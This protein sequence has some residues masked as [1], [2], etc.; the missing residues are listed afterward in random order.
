MQLGTIVSVIKN[1]LTVG[2]GCQKS[3]IKGNSAKIALN[4]T[5]FAVTLLNNAVH[6]FF[7]QFYDII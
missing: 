4:L 5:F 3:K 2:R 7:I 6:Q 1:V